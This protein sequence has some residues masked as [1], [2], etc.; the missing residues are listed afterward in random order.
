MKVKIDRNLCIG[1]GACVTICPDVFELKDDEKVY[2]KDEKAC[3]RC[4][5]KMAAQGCPVQAIS[6]EM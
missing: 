1:C 6:I 5:C 3:E 4:D 2:V